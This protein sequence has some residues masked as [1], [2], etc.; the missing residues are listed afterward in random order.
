[1]IHLW[2]KGK[3]YYKVICKSLKIKY[4]MII[5]N[6]KEIGLVIDI[7]LKTKNERD[8]NLMKGN[9]RGLNLK[10]KKEKSHMKKDM[11]N[12]M[13]KNEKNQ[14]IKNVKK[15]QKIKIQIYNLMRKNFRLEIKLVL[16]DMTNQKYHLQ[17]KDKLTCKSLVT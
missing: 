13:I 15:V 10:I 12:H 8:L 3:V 1:M 7:N 4:K 5:K 14:M 2:Y 16:I 6:I 9:E 11:K 17:S